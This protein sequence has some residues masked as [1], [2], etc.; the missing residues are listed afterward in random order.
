[1]IRSFFE[2]LE[3]LLLAWSFYANFEFQYPDSFVDGNDLI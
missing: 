3:I 2:N 1:M